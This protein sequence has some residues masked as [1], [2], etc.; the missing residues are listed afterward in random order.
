MITV[1]DASPSV[2]PLFCTQKTKGPHTESRREMILKDPHLILDGYMR[3]IQHTCFLIKCF[4]REDAYLIQNHQ[5]YWEFNFFLFWLCWIVLAA[6]GL[7]LGAVSR[8]YSLMQCVN[9]SFSLWWLP[10]LWSTELLWCLGSGSRARLLRLESIVVLRDVVSSGP[11]MEHMYPTLAGSVFTTESP[12]KPSMWLL[13][14]LILRIFL[15]IWFAFKKQI[16]SGSLW[17]VWVTP[18]LHTQ[19]RSQD[20]ALSFG[21]SPHTVNKCVSWPI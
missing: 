13:D 10:L 16:G 12:G 20:H 8:G 11:G 18:C 6:L 9:F 15:R 17:W 3:K 5:L 21:L 1:I 4:R 7:F 14:L 2:N 19:L